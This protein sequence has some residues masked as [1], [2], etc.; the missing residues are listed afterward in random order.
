MTIS[1]EKDKGILLVS[2][3][4]KL[5]KSDFKRMSR[6]ADN[7]IATHGNLNGILVFADK[8]K[9]WKD[10]GSFLSHVD[11]VRNHFNKMG[12]IAVLTDNMLL[13]NIPKVASILTKNKIRQFG[14]QKR[15]EAEDWLKDVA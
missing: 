12:R 8:F 1:L 2:P 7:Y 6:K 13:S 10:F 3:K 4:G 11:F 14:K 5:E 9:G 15:V